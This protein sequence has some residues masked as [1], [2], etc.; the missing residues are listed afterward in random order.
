MGMNCAQLNT[1]GRDCEC[2]LFVLAFVHHSGSLFSGSKFHTS[3][4]FSPLLAKC[5][6]WVDGVLMRTGSD[7]LKILCASRAFS[8]SH[9]C[10]WVDLSWG[11]EGQEGEREVPV[12]EN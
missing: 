7:N 1:G 5:I 3:P 4:G 12:T 9:V 8:G 10:T 11:S 6:R 2:V